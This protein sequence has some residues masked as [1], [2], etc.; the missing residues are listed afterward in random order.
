MNV[1]MMMMR[2]RM[3]VMVKTSRIMLTL[4]L[5]DDIMMMDEVVLWGKHFTNHHGKELSSFQSLIQHTLWLQPC[6]GDYEKFLGNLS[7]ELYLKYYKTIIYNG[8]GLELKHTA[9]LTKDGR[10]T[11][12]DNDDGN[13]EEWV[14]FRLIL[15]KSMLYNI[16]R[17]N[18]LSS[19]SSEYKGPFMDNI[20]HHQSPPCYVPPP[21]FLNQVLW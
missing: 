16:S 19:L 14:L 15:W 10:N 20:S 7:I 17:Y 12:G 18:I 11:G 1:M 3:K 2:R 13:E 21:L 6:G 5:L 8:P 9:V 4:I